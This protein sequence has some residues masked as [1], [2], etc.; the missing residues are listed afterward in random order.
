MMKRLAAAFAAF[1]CLSVA[2]PASAQAVDPIARGLAALAWRPAVSKGCGTVTVSTPCL[3]ITETW[4]NGST[5]FGAPLTVNVTNTASASGSLLFDLQNGGSSKFNVDKS[6]SLTI[7]TGTTN[8]FG[9]SLQT[10]D[11]SLQLRSVASLGWSSTSIGGTTDVILTRDAANTLALRNGTNAQQ[12]NVYNT[13]TD[14]SNNEV[15]SLGWSSVSNV[16][17]VNVGA[18][19]TGTYRP[20]AFSVGGQRRW[21]FETTGNFDASVSNTYDIGAGGSAR[22]VWLGRDLVVTPGTAP[23][24][25]ACGT[26]PALGTN[27]TDT[28]GTVTTGTATPTSCTITFGH[29]HTNVPSCI[30]EDSTALANLTS[31]TVSA[32]AIVVTTTAASSQNLVYHCIGLGA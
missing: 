16:F 28:A 14:G 18:I 3:T 31:F 29:A 5:V 23:T 26:S 4:N 10:T 7:A 20:L 15:A 13:Y 1:L 19:G 11:T 24:V 17:V 2:V 8:S 22:D 6:G 9:A 30:V 25:S 27:S 21:Q 12:F 32:S